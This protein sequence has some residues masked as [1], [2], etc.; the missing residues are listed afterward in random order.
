MSELFI[1]HMMPAEVELLWEQMSRGQR[2]RALKNIAALPQRPGSEESLLSTA[3][4]QA[5]ENETASF[6]PGLSYSPDHVINYEVLVEVGQHAEETFARFWLATHRPAE[7]GM[8]L[9]RAVEMY[10]YPFW[11]WGTPDDYKR[12]CLDLLRAVREARA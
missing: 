12:A 9:W 3:R 11:E 7:W 1:K 10:L 4:R 2:A 5:F 8:A 6:L